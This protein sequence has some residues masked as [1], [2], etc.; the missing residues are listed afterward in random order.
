MPQIPN[1]PGQPCPKAYPY[2]RSPVHLFTHAPGHTH[3]QGHQCHLPVKLQFSIK[4]LRSMR[5][6]IPN[7][8][9]RTPN[10]YLVILAPS[11]S[12]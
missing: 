12:I 4:Y 7:S 1:V 9:L 11:Q 3:A 10:I 2:L 8:K 5:W 6:Q